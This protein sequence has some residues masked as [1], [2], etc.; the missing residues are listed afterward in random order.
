MRPLVIGSLVQAAMNQASAMVFCDTLMVPTP[1]ARDAASTAELDRQLRGANGD[2]LLARE[3]LWREPDSQDAARILVRQ[4]RAANSL[5]RWGEVLPFPLA[6]VL[7]AWH[8]RATQSTNSLARLLHFFEATAA[9]TSTVL[10][11]ALARDPELEQDELATIRQK[12][13]EY[14]L[15]FQ[16]ASF[17]SWKVVL[18]RLGS[19][20]RR[21]LKGDD[22]D[23]ARVLAA[24][25]QPPQA[26]LDQ[27]LHPAVPR[28]ISTAGARRN[29]WTGHGG[30]GASG[31]A[32]TRD[33]EAELRLLL[34]E[35]RHV[36]GHAFTRWP[37]YQAGVMEKK[38]RVYTQQVILVMGDRTPFRAAT[39]EL[40]APLDTGTLALVS[41]DA[42]DSLPLL[43]FVSLMS[44][45]RT[46][47]NA[48][49]YYNRIEGTGV[50]MVSYHHEHED[51]L[52]G[53][54]AEVRA[55]LDRMVGD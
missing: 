37:L 47:V 48:C 7:W 32:V 27:L 8:S 55:A 51:A 3:R 49:Y 33:R 19:T 45:P 18:E 9:F 35:L 50:R 16:R 10:L 22:D 30:A 17:G 28:I 6:S 21:M 46:A 40:F 43:P 13:A 12:L 39:V 15:T 2:L 41:E 5:E 14:G 53:D 38:G 44:G 4:V 11:S 34:E 25:G 24:F 29:E 36:L 23:R 1:A 26:S 42:S 31:E 20:Y 52:V 54:F